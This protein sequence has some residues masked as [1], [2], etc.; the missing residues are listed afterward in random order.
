MGE[1][2]EG[3]GRTRDGEEHDFLVRPLLAGIVVDGDA[4]RG[5]LVFLRGVGDVPWRVRSV[6][7]LRT[8]LGMLGCSGEVEQISR[9]SLREDDAVRKGISC[10]GRCHC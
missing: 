1:E 4:A 3:G 10:S 9:W 2:S 8:K 6:R 5:D 7:A